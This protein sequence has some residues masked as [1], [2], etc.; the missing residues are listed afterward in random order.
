MVS[1]FHELIAKLA[2]RIYR[3]TP[4]Q[5]SIFSGESILDS[6]PPNKTMFRDSIM[7]PEESPPSNFYLLV[8]TAK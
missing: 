7:K 5:Q 6:Q 2:N 8:P 1:I 4:N 3:D